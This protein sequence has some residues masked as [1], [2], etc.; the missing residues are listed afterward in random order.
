MRGINSGR[1]VLLPMVTVCGTVDISSGGRVGRDQQIGE[2]L[3]RDFAW[4]GDE[5][6]NAERIGIARVAVGDGHGRRQVGTQMR[7]AGEIDPH[8]GALPLLDCE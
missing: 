3:D 6:W 1:T 5:D 7:A 2:H 4:N 8:V